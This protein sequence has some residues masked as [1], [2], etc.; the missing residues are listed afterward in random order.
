MSRQKLAKKYHSSDNENN[1]SPNIRME[2]QESDSRDPKLDDENRPRFAS[3]VSEAY[4]KLVGD[5]NKSLGVS[6]V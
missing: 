3:I 1:S 6:N 4:T 5:S 2:S